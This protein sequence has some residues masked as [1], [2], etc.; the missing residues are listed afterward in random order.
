MSMYPCP[1]PQVCGV[2]RHRNMRSCK[3]FKERWSGTDF[4]QSSG[5][6]NLANPAPAASQSI[7]IPSVEVWWD[8]GVIRLQEWRNEDG[9]LHRTDGPAMI[10][11]DKS[12]NTV[13]EEYRVDGEFQKLVYRRQLY[14][15]SQEFHLNQDVPLR[16]LEQQ[17]PYI[18]F[19][20]CNEENRPA[21]IRKVIT[22]DDLTEE[23]WYRNG[24]KHREDG[25][26]VV[27]TRVY[28]G[29]KEESHGYYM[30]GT[31]MTEEQYEQY[32]ESLASGLTDE[33]S[34]AWAGL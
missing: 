26:A 16:R 32:T 18:L 14:G 1:N 10:E 29:I 31:I 5:T 11:Y 8:E 12:G 22:G 9:W 25:P 15:T 23:V 30:D 7:G 17:V 19:G 28:N 20:M 4:Q 33:M 34:R 3:V 21:Y 6:P 27:I 2:W 13:R 24:T